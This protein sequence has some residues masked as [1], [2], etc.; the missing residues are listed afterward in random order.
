MR[1]NVLAHRY[2]RVDGYG[3]YAISTIKAL[4]HAGVDIYADTV[5]SLEMP[6]WMLRARGLDF[7][8]LSLCI[9]PPH[10]L[11]AVPGRQF[12]C[13]MYES[14]GLPSG[15]ADHVNRKAERLIVPSEWLVD[16]FQEAGVKRPIHVVHGGVDPQ[17]F[18]VVDTPPRD[19]VYTFL[20]FG[21]RGS[22][23]GQD[24]AW[25]AFYEAFGDQP[26]VRLLIKARPCN[27]GWL[28]LTHSDRRIAVWREDVDSLAE[29]FQ[30]ADCFVF[31]TRGEGWGLP[32]REAACMG[33]PVITTRWS[34]TAVGI[35]H[36]AIPI[37]RYQLVPSLLHGDWAMPDVSEVAAHMRWCYE[38][39]E[40]AQQKGLAAAQ[41]LRDHQTWD[42]SAR[43]M[44]DLLEQVS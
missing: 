37:E 43:Q 21:D 38:H 41:W 7:S 2:I 13:S 18:P 31:P 35:D 11:H 26:D 8:R 28:D 1:I 15:W 33:K 22:R 29:V 23:K 10:E 44:L 30:M 17:E 19:D 42:H 6:G 32:P 25:A 34:G 39:R 9:M 4:M 20:A 5:W 40:A 3:R 24:I 16:V 36:W 12:L 14:T 27:L